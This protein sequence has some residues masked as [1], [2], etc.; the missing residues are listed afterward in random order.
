MIIETA[1]VNTQSSY[2]GSLATEHQIHP[3]QNIKLSPWNRKSLN[4][5]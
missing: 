1:T 4:F 3:V 2:C 5:N